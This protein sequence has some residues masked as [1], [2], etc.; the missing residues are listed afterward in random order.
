LGDAIRSNRKALVAVNLKL[1]DEEAAKFWPIYD[2]YQQELNAIGDRLVGVIKDYSAHFSD[3]SDD[4]AT[5][6]VDDYLA[7]EAD[8]VKVRRAYVDEFTKALPGRKVARFYQIENKLDAVLRYDPLPR[9]RWRRRRAFG[10][11]GRSPAPQRR[12]ARCVCRPVGVLSCRIDGRCG[13][14]ENR[15]IHQARRLPR[16]ACGPLLAMDHLKN[17]DGSG[18]SGSARPRQLTINRA[19]AGIRLFEIT[20]RKS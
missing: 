7:V 4:K 1:T 20:L 11:V 19:A 6:L 16:A 14:D 12:S 9:S 8:R 5:K 18:T 13:N 3:L 17:A 10:Q 15:P 2:R